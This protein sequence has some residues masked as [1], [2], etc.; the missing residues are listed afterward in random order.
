M[1]YRNT[2]LGQPAPPLSSGGMRQ[3]REVG[4]HDLPLAAA[5]DEDQRC[6]SVLLKRCSHPP[7]FSGF[8]RSCQLFLA[9]PKIYALTAERRPAV[10]ERSEKNTKVPNAK[11]TPALNSCQK[12][13]FLLLGGQMAGELYI[14][15]RAIASKDNRQ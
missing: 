1:A 4:A 11:A 3:M 12:L 5:F 14:G 8:A 9:H 15:L 6:A 7:G 13:I 10:R 2:A